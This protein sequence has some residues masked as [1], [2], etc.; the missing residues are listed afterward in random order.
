M[1]S[2]R[3]V[4]LITIGLVVSALAT[5]IVGW[6]GSRRGPPANRANASAALDILVAASLLSVLVLTL[7]P[8]TSPQPAVDL[9]PFQQLWR[10][11]SRWETI[12][13]QMAANVMLF[14]PLGLFVPARWRALDSLARVTVAAAG[15]SF[16]IEAWQFALVAGRQSSLTDLVLNTAGA[17]LGYAL[18]VLVRAAIRPTSQ[19]SAAG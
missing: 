17:T 19:P 14:I 7:P 10:N 8:T 11:P 13:T 15:F 4:P 1:M 2:G 6:V 12:I 16:L 3:L 5:L 9:V 18:L